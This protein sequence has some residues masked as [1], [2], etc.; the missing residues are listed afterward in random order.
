VCSSDLILTGRADSF[1]KAVEIFNKET[2]ENYS[3]YLLRSSYI[4]YFGE[5]DYDAI[6]KGFGWKLKKRYYVETFRNKDDPYAEYM[7]GE[8]D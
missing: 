8:S 5:E 6:I 3:D 1:K 7:S 2:G 4:H